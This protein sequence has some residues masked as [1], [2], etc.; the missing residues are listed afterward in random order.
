MTADNATNLCF[1][2]L[3]FCS[4]RLLTRLFAHHPLLVVRWLTG[5]SLRRIPHTWNT[6]TWQ[7]AMRRM[8]WPQLAMGLAMV[9]LG[10]CW[11]VA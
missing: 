1:S 7:Q 10:G 9:A 5:R 2:G 11:R 3:A 6:S 4:V 8:S